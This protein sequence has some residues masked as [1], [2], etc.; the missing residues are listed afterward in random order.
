VLISLGPQFH[1]PRERVRQSYEPG[2]HPISG[3]PA[4][5]LAPPSRGAP[6]FFRK[7]PPFRGREVGSPAHLFHWPL[8]PA[9]TSRRGRPAVSPTLRRA[10]GP[11]E[12]QNATALL[13]FSTNWSLAGRCAANHAAVCK[14]S[15]WHHRSNVGSTIQVRTLRGGSAW[16]GGRVVGRCQ[17][18]RRVSLTH[19]SCRL[20]PTGASM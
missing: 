13:R 10:C 11:N 17:L 16:R 15:G 3:S 5:A 9:L 2:C 18:R 7:V 12:R 6:F 4:E 19:R 14:R 20:S 8:R 1:R